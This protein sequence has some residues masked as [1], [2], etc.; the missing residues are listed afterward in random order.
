LRAHG[1]P[2]RRLA[3]SSGFASITFALTFWTNEPGL[4]ERG[5][6]ILPSAMF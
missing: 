4:L 5:A 2:G 6:A 3:A 1:Q